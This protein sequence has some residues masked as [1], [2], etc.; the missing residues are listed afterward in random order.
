MRF[1][2]FHGASWE[3]YGKLKGEAVLLA[4]ER[5]T[6]LLR[7]DLVKISVAEEFKFLFFIDKLVEHKK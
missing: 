3:I 7:M 4:C 5:D 2:V 1:V 6:S